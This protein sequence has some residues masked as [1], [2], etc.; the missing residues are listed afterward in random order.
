MTRKDYILIADAIAGS[1]SGRSGPAEEA[2]KT[3]AEDLARDLARANSNFD[4]DRF[5]RACGVRP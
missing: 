2:L 4:D 5:L 3:F 1:L